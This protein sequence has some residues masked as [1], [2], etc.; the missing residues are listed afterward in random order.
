MI[1]YSVTDKRQAGNQ[2]HG[3]NSAN[4]NVSATESAYI[5]LFVKLTCSPSLILSLLRS[6]E[7]SYCKL[8]ILK[9]YMLCFEIVNCEKY[10]KMCAKIY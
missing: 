3:G 7:N 5:E 9:K 6:F 10:T 1:S 8:V 2:I 4:R